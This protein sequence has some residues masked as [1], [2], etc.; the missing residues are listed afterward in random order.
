MLC[1]KWRDSPTRLIKD[2]G[3]A[4]LGELSVQLGGLYVPPNRNV[5]RTNDSS[6]APS[7]RKDRRDSKEPP[8]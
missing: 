2:E 3:Q 4:A 7:D 1:S 6:K 5:R 8:A